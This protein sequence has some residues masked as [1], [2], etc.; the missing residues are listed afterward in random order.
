MGIFLDTGFFFS[1]IA[2]KDYFHKQSLK[3]LR[4]LSEQ[5]YGS[6]YSS[7]YVLN[8][9]MTLINHRTKGNRKDLLIMMKE[10]FIGPKRICNLIKIEKTWLEDI[11]RIQINNTNKGDPISF[12]DSSIVILCNKRNIDKI[13]TFDEHFKKHLTIIN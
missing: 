13:V 1:L 7:D 9:A 8:E 2:K 11:S 10:L 12:T 3:I 5:K 6:I 4:E